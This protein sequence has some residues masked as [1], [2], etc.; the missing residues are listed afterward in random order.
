M[1]MNQTKGNFVS[2]DAA[3]KQAMRWSI[4][5]VK[6]G[7]FVRIVLEGNFNLADQRRMIDDIVSRDFWTPGMS[8]LFDN[9]KLEYGATTVQLMK[10]A[11]ANHL[12]YDARIGDGKAAL[13]MKSTPDFMRGRQYEIITQGKVSAKVGIFQ[14]ETE[15]LEWLLA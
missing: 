2:K 7:N 14:E 3:N 12:E 11:G 5:H 13:L 8:A 6:A 15:A 4:E 10:E 9:R 1:P